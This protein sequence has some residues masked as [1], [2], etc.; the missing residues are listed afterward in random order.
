MEEILFR[1]RTKH[2]GWV[3]GALVRKFATTYIVQYNEDTDWY[4]DIKV[5]DD[6]VGQYTGRMDKD[7]TRMFTGDILGGMGPIVYIPAEARFGISVCGELNEVLFSELE[8]EQLLVIG[9]I[10]DN[11]DLLEEL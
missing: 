2:K 6:T 5:D 8:Q 11:P 3:Y 4:D 10:H 9:N 7:S 1:G